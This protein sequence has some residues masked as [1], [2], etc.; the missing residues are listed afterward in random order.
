MKK[1]AVHEAFVSAGCPAGDSRTYERTRRHPMNLSDKVSMPPQVMARQVA[2][3]TVVLD[4]GL[5]K[6]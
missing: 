2:E 4:Q 6:I 1:V 5:I 3:E